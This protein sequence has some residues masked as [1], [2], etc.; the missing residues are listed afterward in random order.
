MPSAIIWSRVAILGDVARHEA[1]L[2]AL[3]HDDGVLHLLRLGEAEH[4][5]AEILRPV[6]PAQA[7]ARDRA[8]AQM[9]A[10]EARRGD[11]DLGERLR[12]GH[13]VDLGAAR[14]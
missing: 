3:R 7:A 12:R 13:R 1:A 10:L 9:H 6:G 5:G 8:A 14:S 11:E 2:G 4:F